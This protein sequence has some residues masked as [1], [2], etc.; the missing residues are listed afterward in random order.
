MGDFISEIWGHHYDVLVQEGGLDSL[1]EMLRLREFGEKILVVSDENVA[2]LY[3]ER[4]LASLQSAHFSAT[5]FIIPAGEKH[6]N[7]E[8]VLA[9][10]RGFMEANLT[11]KSLVIALGGGIVSDLVGFC[12]ATFMRGCSWAAIPT[13]LL[14]MVD[15]AIGGKTGFDL[16]EGKNLVGAFYPPKFVL[17]DPDVLLTLPVREMRA[18]LAEVI[19]HGIIADPDLFY[20]CAD[21]WDKVIS[22]IPCH[23]TACYGS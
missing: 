19:K 14:A 7:I 22:Q 10:W 9:L 16:P 8:T 5:K 13:T 1:G 2:P 21:G 15:A 4:V 20:L 3:A 17:A 18:G 12:A 6:K 11:R 23:C